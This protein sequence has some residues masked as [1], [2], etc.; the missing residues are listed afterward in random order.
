MAM[1]IALIGLGRFGQL[2]RDILNDQDITTFDKHDS[3]DN[4]N[5]FDTIFLTVPI[6][7]FDAVIQE[8]APQLKPGTTVIDTCSVKIYPT[9]CMKKYLSDDITIIATH[10]LFG[11]DSYYRSHHNK[12]MMHCAQ[13]NIA[14]YDHWKHYFA[15]KNI[16]II[17]MTP[18][19]H[20]RY[21]AYSQGVTH[22]IGR[23]L[24]K[25]DIQ[26]TPIDT[27]GFTQLLTIMNQTCH[28]SIALFHDLQLYNPY[29]KECQKHIKKAL[30]ELIENP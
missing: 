18:D 15:Q 13:G 14:S 2:L 3:L 8:I 30:T 29:T 16:S 17:E 27:L 12:M 25:A 7:T 9:D 23:T 22:L 20:D 26:S 19:D 21:A 11:P 10:P 6:H 4:L 28:D 5:R 24:Q 1:K